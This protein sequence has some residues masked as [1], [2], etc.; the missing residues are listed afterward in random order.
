MKVVDSADS[1]EDDDELE[2]ISAKVKPM[3][4]VVFLFRH[5]SFMLIFVS[6]APLR[7]VTNVAREASRLFRALTVRASTILGAQ[8]WRSKN[9]SS[10]MLKAPGS[11]T[12]AYLIILL[13][14][15]VS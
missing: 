13:S 15:C 5:Y 7:S 4:K 1:N 8:D 3:S 10:L 14:N 9:S 11:A 2:K 12:I 6:F